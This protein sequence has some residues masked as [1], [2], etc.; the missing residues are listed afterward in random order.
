MRSHNTR[1]TAEK[2]GITHKTMFSRFM[3]IFPHSLSYR[4][5]VIF[6]VFAIISLFLPSPYVIE[7]PGPTKNVLAHKKEEI[8]KVE[9]IP[10]YLDKG[11]LRMVTVNATGVPG[12]PANNA[13]ALVAWFS[14]THRV[15]PSEAIFPVGQSVKQYEKESEAQMTGSQNSAQSAAFNFLKTLGIDTSHAHVH[16]H[17]NDIGGPSAGMIYALGII[18]TL[19][20]QQLTGGKVI[21]GTGTIDSKGKV[22]PIGGIRL[23]MI[24]AVRDGAQWFLAPSSNCDEVVGHI[25]HGLHVVR[26]GNL[27]EAYHALKSIGESR[28]ADLPQCSVR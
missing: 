15:I 6:F 24:G 20:P 25:P 12:Y 19:T 10:T 23:K 3:Q 2:S 9:G 27:S 14:P 8:I 22:G 5:L 11:Q 28:T 16:I 7:G 17:V 13:E 4:L 26:V 1:Y 18:D 21:A